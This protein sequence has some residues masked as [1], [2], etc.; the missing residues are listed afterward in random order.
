L[1]YI[2]LFDFDPKMNIADAFVLEDLSI[3]NE[4]MLMSCA[5][6]Y[7]GD[8][9]I[10]NLVSAL[11]QMAVFGANNIDWK[12]NGVVSLRNSPIGK[13]SRQFSRDEQVPILRNPG[14]VFWTNFSTGDKFLSDNCR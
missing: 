12:G 13:I 10:E 11:S 14:N 5:R 1:S 6:K 3:L 4:I 8:F 9:G 7:H 2:V